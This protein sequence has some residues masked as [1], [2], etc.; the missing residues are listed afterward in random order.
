MGKGYC[1]TESAV[2]IRQNILV[3]RPEAE[4]SLCQS[5]NFLLLPEAF[6]F[7]ACLIFGAPFPWDTNPRLLQCKHRM[8]KDMDLTN[9]TFIMF[10]G[11]SHPLVTMTKD[12]VPFFSMYFGSFLWAAI[13]AS[14]AVGDSNCGNTKFRQWTTKTVLQKTP[15][16]SLAWRFYRWFGSVR[17]V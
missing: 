15:S 11:V 7:V 3:I 14:L 10:T 2:Y 16:A 13:Y 1:S 8:S 9:R 12:Y 5:A 17:N 4:D 6:V